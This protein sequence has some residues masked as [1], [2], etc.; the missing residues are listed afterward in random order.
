MSNKTSVPPIILRQMDNLRKPINMSKQHCESTATTNK[1][2]GR[3]GYRL[4]NMLSMLGHQ[5]QQNIHRTS[6]GWVSSPERISQTEQ[7]NCPR[8][9]R[10]ARNKFRTPGDM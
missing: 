5:Q 2:I 1:M 4:F 10:H 6:S 9:W 3:S 7:K 8:P